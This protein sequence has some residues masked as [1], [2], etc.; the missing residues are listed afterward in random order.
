MPSSVSKCAIPTR[1]LSITDPQINIDEMVLIAYCT[2]IES[3]LAARRR[4]LEARLREAR[5]TGSLTA[6]R[7]ARSEYQ[8]LREDFDHVR[9]PSNV[10]SLQTT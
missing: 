2:T 7:A 4:S 3:E 8:A 5:E 6:R 10:E 1:L 9:N